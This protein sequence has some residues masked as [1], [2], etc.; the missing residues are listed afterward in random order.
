MEHFVEMNYVKQN[1]N[2]NRAEQGN[3]FQNDNCVLLL[4]YDLNLVNALF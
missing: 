4:K 2:T 1:L 3:S